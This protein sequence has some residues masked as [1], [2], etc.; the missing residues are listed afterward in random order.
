MEIQNLVDLTK[1]PFNDSDPEWT[2]FV[3]IIESALKDSPR[4]KVQNKNGLPFS[5]S[6]FQNSKK[7]SNG[8]GL[9]VLNDEVA[10]IST[11][12]IT[13]PGSLID[14]DSFEIDASEI[15]YAFLYFADLDLSDAEELLDFFDKFGFLT[16]N[17]EDVALIVGREHAIWTESA[18]QEPPKPV[19]R[20]AGSFNECLETYI[21]LQLEMRTLIRMWRVLSASDA[22]RLLYLEYSSLVPEPSERE[23]F[24][25]SDLANRE[26]YTTL[27][28][29]S[30]FSVDESECFFEIRN[31]GDYE[32]LTPSEVTKLFTW[33]E[34][35][36]C[37][38][39]N[40]LL[41]LVQPIERV[42]VEYQE[43]EKAPKRRAKSKDKEFKRVR[44][45]RRHH[46]NLFS[47]II[48]QLKDA[49]FQDRRFSRCM[50]CLNWM[51]Y[52]P[53][54]GDKFY[55]DSDCRTRAYRRAKWLNAPAMV[56]NNQALFKGIKNITTEQLSFMTDQSCP[57][58][59]NE[60]K[61]QELVNK[62]ADE[63]GL[64]KPDKNKIHDFI[65]SFVWLLS[66]EAL[67][68]NMLE[69][70]GLPDFER[71]WFHEAQMKHYEALRPE[72][73]PTYFD[74]PKNWIDNFRPAK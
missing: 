24:W 55:C 36:F 45:S 35:D 33:L 47:L 1:F 14:S 66:T 20:K 43:I 21:L 58:G 29:R 18:K 27:L 11:H 63:F 60:K 54:G 73:A 41:A 23:N 59:E 30:V 4:D 64:K 72:R 62:L 50:E 71:E 32:R 7:G 9:S 22:Q 3:E 74:W 46:K 38:R 6:S 26:S 39:L 67:P 28:N 70:Y 13:I 57:T 19:V 65:L 16:P 2:D 40:R 10:S 68:E 69:H 52:V 42:S 34:K 56:A 51:D 15:P 37:D 8:T 31:R 53:K 48:H 17:Y 12:K 61:A 25:V 44:V 5:L 49:F